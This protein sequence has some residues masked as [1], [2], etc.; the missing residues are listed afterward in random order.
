MSQRSKKANV[1]A[2]QQTS[3]SLGCVCEWAYRLAT[4]HTMV[5]YLSLQQYSTVRRQ[6]WDEAEAQRRKRTFTVEELL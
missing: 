1:F 2:V 6:P 5:E 4:H 3:L